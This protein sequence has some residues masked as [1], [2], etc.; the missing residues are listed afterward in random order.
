MLNKEDRKNAS[1]V[2]KHWRQNVFHP[3]W[4]PTMTFKIEQ[5]K[6]EKAKF[7]IHTFGRLATEAKIKLNSLSVE[8]MEE[9]IHL[10]QILRENN[11]LRSFVIEPSHCRFEAPSKIIGNSD[12]PWNIMKLLRPCLPKLSTFSIGC[13]ED[14]TYFLDDILKGLSPSK[15]THLGLASVKDD[16]V[17]YE[18]AYF[19]P[20]MIARFTKLKV[21]SIDYDQLSDEFLYNLEAVKELERLVV[22][23]H[24]I[25]EN[26]PSTSNR[27]WDNFRQSHP[28]CEFRLTIIHAF[29]D[30]KNIH[31]T[32]MRRCMPL[33]HL[34]VFFCENVNLE[35]IQNLSSHYGE[36]L[37]SIMWVDSLSHN[38][39]SWVFVKPLFD[40]SPDPFVLAAWLCKNLEEFVLY[41]YKYW[42]ENLVAIGRLRGENLKKLEIAENDVIFNPGPNLED[43]LLVFVKS[44]VTSEETCN[45]TN[46]CPVKIDQR[47][48]RSSSQSLN[49]EPGLPQPDP[50]RPILLAFFPGPIVDGAMWVTDIPKSLQKPWKPTQQTE[51]HPVICNPTDGDSDEYLLPIV[52]ADLH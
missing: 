33:T 6:I 50:P 31:E 13:I 5:N 40:E 41:G 7:Y 39:N 37:R 44:T 19:D 30:I 49:Q 22:H 48:S 51:L 43:A 21:L 52:L 16:P 42:E 3:K 18:V 36:T 17:K 11:N 4:W 2:C 35:L 46:A 28:N 23:L 9:F 24:S 14:L 10:L 26:H 25:Q 8:C 1:A 27:A 34:K 12:D 29:N 32:V 45:N 15:V 20:K 47:A 38:D